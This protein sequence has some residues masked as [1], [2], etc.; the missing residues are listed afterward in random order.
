M[1]CEAC[2]HAF[3]EHREDVQPVPQT[4]LARK[5]PRSP[6]YKASHHSL[7]SLKQCAS[8]GC[9]LCTL[10]W[11]AAPLE[12]RELCNQI[13]ASA[14]YSR[15]L[16]CHITVDRAI[17][18]SRKGPG[19]YLVEYKYNMTEKHPRDYVQPV[20]Q[21]FRLLPSEGTCTL[22][23]FKSQLSELLFCLLCSLHRRI[24]HLA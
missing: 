8:D 9:R 16:P 22:L 13:L 12:V 18:G 2:N 19:R 15:W 1:L 3:R 4:I 17:F 5:A 7:P 14:S 11:E 23:F 20:K 10:F 21:H 24:T 6:F